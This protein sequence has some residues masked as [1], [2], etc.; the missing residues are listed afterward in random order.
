MDF[1]SS[2]GTLAVMGSDSFITFY[3]TR[4]YQIARSLLGYGYVSEQSTGV[5]SVISL[6][7]NGQHLALLSSDPTTGTNVIEV[8]DLLLTRVMWTSPLQTDPP[9]T[10][11][12]LDTNPDASLVMVAY[13]D[14]Q[15]GGVI[16][17]DLASGTT[18][19]QI[20]GTSTA[21]A[22]FDPNGRLHMIGDFT[23]T[24]WGVPG[25]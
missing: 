1:L 5:A 9:D 15:S 4:D 12:D 18:L 13:G 20:E 19:R 2:G 25:Q 21:R 7:P 6:T 22:F 17:H 16:L 24:V 10:A 11:R 3:T 23:W 8:W 14:G